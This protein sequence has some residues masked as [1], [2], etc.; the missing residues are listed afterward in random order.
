MMK[1]IA[2]LFLAGALVLCSCGKKESKRTLFE[3]R[4]PEGLS[5][6]IDGIQ[7][8]SRKF[9]LLSGT[10]LMRFSAPGYRTEY[11]TVKV[12]GEKYA[13]DPELAPVHSSVLIQSSPAG[14]TVTVDGNSRGITP[15]VIRDLPAGK[16]RAE[17]S[18]PGYAGSTA[19]WEIRSGRPE[20]VNV[21][22]DSNMSTLAITSSPSRAR[23]IVEGTEVGETP[24]ELE[25]PEGK[26]VIRL[27][28][29][30][31]NPEERSVRLDKGRKGRLHVKLGQ[32]PGGIRVTS[33]PAGAELFVNGVK[34]GVTPCTVEALEPGVC[35]LKLS[36]QGYDTLETRVQIAPGAT[37]T[38]HYN[39]SSST[40]SV[41]FNVQ[42]VGVEL[43]FRG[44]SL[45]VTKALVEGAESTA[46]FTIGNLPPGQHTVTMFHSLGDP[47]H[48]SFTFTVRK[49]KKTVLKSRRMWISNC[50]IVYISGIRERGFLV[51]SKPGYVV[52]SPETGVQYRVDRPKIR[53]LIMLKGV[54]RP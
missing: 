28:R 16:Y 41:V 48:Q 44:K 42:P 52:F 17:L 6:V 39:L 14:A 46:D 35:H 30:G 12:T 5:C 29:A 13:F 11:R 32:K 36:R 2:L 19:E 27:E 34:R 53:K 15:L 23:V 37:D 40:G 3:L 33:T 24:L 49:G 7:T 4:G 45:G 25:R 1:R 38:R 47:P 10:Y 9:R 20:V 50:E 31:C 51:E 54:K 8:N 22:L 21:D 43:F 18:K 26:Y